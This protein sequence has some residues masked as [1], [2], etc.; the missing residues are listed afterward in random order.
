MSGLFG[1]KSSGGNGCGCVAAVVFVIVMIIILTLVM[2]MISGPSG[3]SQSVYYTEVPASSYN[4]E[5]LENTSWDG[6]CVI[7][8]IGWISEDG[9]I[10]GLEHK[11]RDF[12]DETGVQPFVYLVGYRSDLVTD[13]DKERFASSF[14]EN[15]IGNDYTFAF[16]YFCEYNPDDVGYMYYEGGSRALGVMDPEAIDI[17]WAICDSE[18]YS[19][20]TTEDA[21]ANTFNRTAS[22]IMTKTA[23]GKDIGKIVLIIVLVIVVAAAI[24]FIMN[25][26]RKLEK[27]RSEETRKILETPL[28]DLASI[29][30]D[31][32][33]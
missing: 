24:V 9:S 5:K 4:R 6:D 3:E 28:D 15:E 19:D 16:F 10:S 11:L 18:W 26:K 12:Y 25:R 7:D 2:S 8:E 31:I 17:F 32:E 21:L 14:Y 20:A 23:T 22:R 27:E 29:E 30:K 13:S 1:R 33:K